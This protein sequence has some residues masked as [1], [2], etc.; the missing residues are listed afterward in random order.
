MVQ[1]LFK[2]IALKKGFVI[3]TYKT[4]SYGWTARLCKMNYDSEHGFIL[5]IGGI[6]NFAFMAFGANETIATIRAYLRIK[7]ELKK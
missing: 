7:E 1:S 3:A 4:N 6:D 2:N 5:P